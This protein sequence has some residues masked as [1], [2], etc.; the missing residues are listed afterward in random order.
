MPFTDKDGHSVKTF[1]KAKHDTESQLLQEFAQGL[2][3]C[4]EALL[5]GAQINGPL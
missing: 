5:S 3:V 1:H 2:Q 4:S